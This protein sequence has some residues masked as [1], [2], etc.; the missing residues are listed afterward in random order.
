M[1]PEAQ[2]QSGSVL[3]LALLV[4]ATLV[5]LS[6]AFSDTAGT[7][8]DLATFFQDTLKAEGLARAGVEAA[9]HRIAMDPDPDVDHLGEDWSLFD[10]TA[11]PME[12]PDGAE[13]KTRIFDEGGKLPLNA[14]RTDDGTIDELRAAQLE[15]LLLDLGLGRVAYAS[16]LDWLDADDVKRL[17]GAETF[18]Y[19]ELEIPY[20]CRNDRFE[21]MGQI[22]LVRGPDT[23]LEP[24]KEGDRRL[25]DYVT[26]YSGALVNVNTAPMEVL[27]CLDEGQDRHLAEATVQRRLNE[28]FLSVEDVRSLPGMDREVFERIREFLTVR[29]STF[30]I[31]SEGRWGEAVCRVHAV[32]ERE[33][34]DVRLVYW[35]VD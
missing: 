30:E 14:V 22:R 6:V 18:Y 33:G 10:R 27:Q 13:L 23:P 3:V 24:G 20:A 16:V 1:I 31:Q 8:V 5:G 12:I 15:R 4:I 34:E 26:I 25:W 2:R 32:A 29:T 11:V 19:E 28:P 7:E 9:L 35:K 21:S 17:D